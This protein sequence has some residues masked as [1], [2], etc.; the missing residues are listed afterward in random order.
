VA[1]PRPPRGVHD[2]VALFPRS[3]PASPPN[4]A[5][6]GPARGDADERPR[7]PARGAV[8]RSNGSHRA[9]TGDDRGA[10]MGDAARG[11]RRAV[12]E[13]GLRARLSNAL[14]PARQ[15][16]AVRITLL[17]AKWHALLTDAY[18][19]VIAYIERLEQRPAATK[20]TKRLVIRESVG[21]GHHERQARRLHP[22]SEAL[23]S[24]QGGT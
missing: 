20:G 22:R 23:H 1:L 14:P 7:V 21:G 5:A 11:A 3:A 4:G 13:T 12:D 8:P 24:H 17:G 18:P 15:L 6:R 10:P 2:D 19:N 16:D 9:R